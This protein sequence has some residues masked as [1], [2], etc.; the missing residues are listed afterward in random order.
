MR[1]AASPGEVALRLSDLG[2]QELPRVASL[3]ESGEETERSPVGGPQ[4]EKMAVWSGEKVI[5][6][7]QRVVLGS[8]TK[9]WAR[10]GWV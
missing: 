4:G 3:K 5:L 6:H 10:D 7:G 8:E 2:L 1:P 9:H